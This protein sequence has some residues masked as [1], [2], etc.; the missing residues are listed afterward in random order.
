MVGNSNT[1]WHWDSRP[2]TPEPAIPW[3]GM[4]WPDGFPVSYTEAFAL[5]NYTEPGAVAQP[6]AFETF[7]PA[8]KVASGDTFLTI[9]T[10]AGYELPLAALLP[11][12]F[13]LETTVW[14]A[15]TQNHSDAATVALLDG[16]GKS[17]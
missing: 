11:S 10:T 6:V 16:T 17:G 7:L 13:V 5:K 3:C 2:G 9:N 8:D 1:R 15:P 12:A 4:L 14:P